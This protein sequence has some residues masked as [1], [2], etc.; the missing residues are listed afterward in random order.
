[1]SVPVAERALDPETGRWLRDLRAGGRTAEKADARLH[2]LE[3]EAARFE[4]SRREAGLTL[5]PGEAEQIA[6]QAASDAVASVHARLGDFGGDRRFTT[7]ARKYAVRAAAVAMRS[8]QA[9]LS[10]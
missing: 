2:A 10:A 4:V 8:R 9:A 3:L 6:A 7:W 5:G 1:M